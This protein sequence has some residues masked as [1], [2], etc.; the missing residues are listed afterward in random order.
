MNKSET[1]V[2]KDEKEEEDDEGA[3]HALTRGELWS[4]T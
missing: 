1:F 3:S 2:V 4:T